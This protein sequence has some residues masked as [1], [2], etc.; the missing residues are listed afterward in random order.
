MLFL[1]ILGTGEWK[2]MVIGICLFLY[3][4]AQQILA[5]V[6]NISEN[7]KLGHYPDTMGYVC[8]NFR[9]STILG[10]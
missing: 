4:F 9:I 8:A 7:K 2:K 5:K 6:K 3:I 1:C 10:F